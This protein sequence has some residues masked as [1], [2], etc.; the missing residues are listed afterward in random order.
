MLLLLAT[1]LLALQP[2]GSEARIEARRLPTRLA[3]SGESLGVL[4]AAPGPLP[5][6]ATPSES[7]SALSGARAAQ[8]E[9]ESQRR[10]LLPEGF[11]GGG[12]CHVQIGRFCYW[13]DEGESTP[14][15]EPAA[16]ASLRNTLKARLARAAEVIPGDQ[17]VAGQRVRYLVE[18]KAFVEA[19]SVA[20][21]CQAESARC[22][23]I[24]GLA[25]HSAGD[26]AGAD[27][28][29]E[30]AL[31][32]LS[33][34][35]RCRWE[36]IT[37]LLPSRYARA[38]RRADCAARRP[39]AD[40][41]WLLADPLWSDAGNDRRT[42]HYSRLVLS[43]L[44]RE[45]RST[46]DLSWGEDMQRMVVRYGWPS[47]WSRLRASLNETSVHV[48]GHEQHPA[49]QFFP[50]DSVLTDLRAVTSDAWDWRSRDAASR[51]QPSFASR[52]VRVD[53]LV[54]RFPR[55]DS[56]V[57]VT[58]ID[59]SRDAALASP[60]AAVY[61]TVRDSLGKTGATMRLRTTAGKASGRLATAGALALLGVDV[62]DSTRRTLGVVRESIEP[63]Q[64]AADGARLS[65]PLLYADPD[66]QDATL[67]DVWPR[68][69]GT[70]TLRVGARVGLYWELTRDVAAIDSVSWTVT[71]VPREA[72]LLRRLVRA[73]RLRPGTAPVHVSFREPLPAGG[74]AARALAVDLRLLPT[75]TY[76]L[77]VRADLAA[78]SHVS[79]T[80]RLAIAR[81]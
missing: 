27:S 77:T 29:F 68:A 31:V 79:A 32:R 51:Y 14:P 63:I 58:A 54:T 74:T 34:V 9:Y 43:E 6:P 35:E 49:F 71:V 5:R 40:R 37:D 17:W 67:D 30:S 20:R 13:Y 78:G 52:V 2:P 55:G 10:R 73:L 69:L 24:R 7:L 8:R 1:S 80:R 3:E 70:A 65:D 12:R 46:Y 26:F 11:G 23:A 42:E 15:T 22:W 50:T 66:R 33:D 28:A 76:D 48:I 44:E 56:T 60:E 18:A 39:L 41:A 38:Y 62:V 36:D 57:V 81:R 59:A 64:R 19:V 45:S 25:L 21:A 61:L 4:S 47:H 16:I 53:A 75:G 72:G